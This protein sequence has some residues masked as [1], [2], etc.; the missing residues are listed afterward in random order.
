MSL[1]ETAIKESKADNTEVID[2]E[3]V[4]I[5][6]PPKS[7]RQEYH[8]GKKE[9]RFFRKNKSIYG[10]QLVCLCALLCMG[11]W[12]SGFRALAICAVSVAVCMLADYLCCRLT[13]KVYNPKDLSTFAAGLCIG[14]MM[15]ASISYWMVAFGGLLA[16]GIKHIFG[17]K[18]NYIF[19]PTCL[20]IAFL[21]ICYPSQMLMFPKVG[22][23]LPVFGEIDVQLYS[24]MES[25]LVKLGTAQELSALDVLIGNFVGPVGTTH[26]LVLGVCGVCLM[27]RRSLSPIVTLVAF[28]AFVGTSFLFPT[29]DNIA[30]A[31]VVELISGNLLFGLIF[32]ASDPQTVPKSALGKVFYGIVIGIFATVFRHMAKV[33]AS[34][35]FVLLLANAVSIHIDLFADKTIVVVQRTFKYLKKALGS[36]ERVKEQAKKGDV[37][38]LNDTQEIIVPLMN[39]NMPAID[40]KIIKAKKQ[41]PKPVDRKKAVEKIRTEKKK[42]NGLFEALRSMKKKKNAENNKT[43]VKKID[44]KTPEHKIKQPPQKSAE[45]NNKEGKK[46]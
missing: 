17:G 35:V 31:I 21:V 4:R 22:E 45:K 11:I 23:T 14:L 40:N 10:D 8:Q 39:Y 9:S 38:S 24:G 1:L 34:F 12:R 5:A 3:G 6:Q 29:Y 13:K 18:D 32:L 25:Y 43:A 15:P 28:G 36:F 16:M 7:Q 37:P 26:V 44:G 19:N 27:F 42:K 30:S 20:A 33:E 46:K 2:A 41:K